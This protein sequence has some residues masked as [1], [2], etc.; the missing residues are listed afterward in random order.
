MTICIHYLHPIRLTKEAITV[1][2][3]VLWLLTDVQLTT[4]PSLLLH[5]IAL[6][7]RQ[8]YRRNAPVKVF[9]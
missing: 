2:N 1:C 5:W 3:T 6:L 7:L 8:I 4:G 9:Q